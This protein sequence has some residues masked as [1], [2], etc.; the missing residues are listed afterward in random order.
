V[1]TADSVETAIHLATS[2]PGRI[3]LLLCGGKPPRMSC[4][5][6]RAA[7]AL[8]R[9]DLR[10]LLVGEESN[11]ATGHCASSLRKPYTADELLAKVSEVLGQPA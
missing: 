10:L 3:D 11:A 5:A 8:T 2:H 1:L 6:A 4:D 9:P 7:L